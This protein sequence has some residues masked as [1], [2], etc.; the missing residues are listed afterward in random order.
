[1]YFY[2]FLSWESTIRL[3][4]TVDQ[5]LILIKFIFII[6]NIFIKSEYEYTSISILLLLS[7][8]LIYSQLKEPI[9]NCRNI[10]LF[11]NLRNYFFLLMKSV[12]LKSLIL[13]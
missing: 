5:I 10:E 11:L 9:Y 2:P 3:N 13:L 8:Y 4:S 6:Q 1:M 7:L 12:K